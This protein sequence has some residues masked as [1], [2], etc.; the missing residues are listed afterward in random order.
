MPKKPSDNIQELFA[1][2]QASYAKVKE[3]ELV[4]DQTAAAYQAATQD[5]NAAAAE[6]NE[7]RAQLNDILGVTAGVSNV[8]MSR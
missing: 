2:V 7:Y 4:K 5:Y 6:L 8:Q 3:R 1:A